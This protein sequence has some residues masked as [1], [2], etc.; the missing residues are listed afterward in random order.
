MGASMM[1]FL[2]LVA[3]PTVMGAIVLSGTTGLLMFF[4]KAVGYNRAAHEI[5]GW[6]LVVGVVAHVATNWASF[7][8][9][10]SKSR[11]LTFVIVGF[12]LFVLGS[13]FYNQPAPSEASPRQRVVST[14]LK[15]P[16]SAVASLTGQTSE[17]VVQSLT[18][19]GF[20]VTG[21]TASIQDIT[22]DDRDAQSRAIEAVLG[23]S[24]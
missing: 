14:V 9:Y 5:F 13:S 24:H 6:A 3:T 2:K 7:K 8:S 15:A 11:P 18:A 16:L 1:R 17:T 21:T 22:G 10:F 4:E 20:S 19:A 23:K 12:F